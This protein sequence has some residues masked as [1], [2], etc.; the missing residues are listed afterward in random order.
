[1]HS[2]VFQQ[3]GKESGDLDKE[4]KEVKIAKT[5]SLSTYEFDV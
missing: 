3:D 1:M 4:G 2:N 5:G